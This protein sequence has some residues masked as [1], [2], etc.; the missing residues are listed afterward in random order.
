MVVTLS[1]RFRDCDPMGH[2]NNAV[3][4]TYF[5]IARTEF[6]RAALGEFA[7]PFILAEATV[8]FR[9]PARF[10]DDLDVAVAVEHVG[11]KSWRF[12]YRITQRATALEVATGSSVQVAYDYAAG[13]TVAIPDP[14]RQALVAALVAPLPERL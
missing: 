1:V 12:G 14:L 2:V 6:M 3:Y 11:G 9:A 13:R 7:L 10:G 5:E 8:S 4:L